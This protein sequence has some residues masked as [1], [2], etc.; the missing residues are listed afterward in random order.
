VIH[1]SIL[2]LQA[3]DRGISPFKIWMHAMP[4]CWLVVDIL[5]F[6]AGDCEHAC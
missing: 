1:C 6:G 5:Y 4:R 2:G 3:A